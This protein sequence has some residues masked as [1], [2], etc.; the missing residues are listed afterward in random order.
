MSAIEGFRISPQQRRLWSLPDGGGVHARSWCRARLRGRLDLLRLA[1]AVDA[2]VARHEILRTRF[3][4]M[5]GLPCQV[6]LDQRSTSVPLCDLGRLAEPHREAALSE[7]WSIARGSE[8]PP[9]KLEALEMWVVRLGGDESALLVSLPAL[10]ADQ[11]TVENLVAEVASLYV[12]GDACSVDP[13]QVEA[14]P[15]HSEESENEEPLQYADLAEVWNDLLED[16]DEAGASAPWLRGALQRQ[17]LPQTLSGIRPRV[18]VEPLATASLPSAFERRAQ[19]LALPVHVILLTGWQAVIMRLVRDPQA[20]IGVAFDGRTYE[21]M[22]QALGLFARYLPMQVSCASDMTFSQ[23]ARAWLEALSEGETWQ[24]Y[25]DWQQLNGSAVPTLDFGFDARVSKAPFALPGLEVSIEGSNAEIDAIGLRLSCVQHDAGIELALFGDSSSAP[26]AKRMLG[27]LV[28]LLEAAVG[29]PATPIGQLPVLGASDRRELSTLNASAAEFPRHATFSQLFKEQAVASA[30]QPAVVCGVTRWS[31]LELAARSSTLSERLLALGVGPEDVVGILG[32]ASPQTLVA[33]LATLEAGGSFLPLDPALPH[34]RLEMMA[35]D[36]RVGVVIVE[37]HLQHLAPSAVQLVSLDGALS[38]LESASPK[39]GNTPEGRQHAMQ[40]AYQLYTSGS[41]GQPK[42]VTI[43]HHSLLNYLFWIN[44]LLEQA[45]VQILP[46]VTRLS[47]DACLKQLLGPLLEGRPVWL[48]EPGEAADPTRV[49]AGLK[50]R[51]GA[52]LNCV[53][54]YWRAALETLEASDLERPQLGALLLGGEPLDAGLV[55]RTRDVFPELTIWNLYGPTEATSNATACKIVSEPSLG[56]P[57]ANASVHVLD[58][59]LQP[60]PPGYE[61]EICLGGVGVARGYLARPALTAE[62]F[63]P[64]DASSIPGARLY[65]TG[66][67]GCIRLGSVEFLGRLDRQIKVR[68]IRIELGEIE[69]TLRSH[70][71]IADAAVL[72]E[73]GSGERLLA[74]VEAVGGNEIDAP[75][76]DAWAEE[77]LPSYMAL[78]R[79]LV[80]AE[81]PRLPS[82][83]VNLGALAETAADFDSD[84]KQA[85]PSTP[86]ER[87]LAKI[88]SEVLDVEQVGRHDSFFRLGGH[89]LLAV[90]LLSRLRQDLAVELTLRELLD[91]EDLAAMASAIEQA[92]ERDEQ[93]RVPALEPSPHGSEV[94]LSFAQERLWFLA[95]LEPSS[96]AYNI[97]LTL[98]LDGQ[99]DVPALASGLRAIGQRHEVL[100]TS[101]RSDEAGP[102]GVIAERCEKRLHCIDLTGL[103]DEDRPRSEH[104]CLQQEATTAFDLEQAPWRSVLVTLGSDRHLLCLTVHHLMWDGWSTG[105][106]FRELETLYRAA[107]GGRTAGLAKLPLQYADY[108]LWQRRWIQGDVLASLLDYWK[109][110]LAELPTLELPL[111]RPRPPLQT[112]RGS[113]RKLEMAGERIEVLEGVARQHSTTLFVVL[114]AAFNVVLQRITGQSDLVVGTDVANRDQGNTELM[115]GLL[116]N[117]LVLRND[118]STNPTLGEVIERVRKTTL[119]AYGHQ[120]LP[121]NLL[122]DAIQPV[123]DLSRNPL[124]QVV[125]G[126][127]NMARAA[128][129]FDDLTMTPTAFDSG[130]SVIDFSLYL[131]ETSGGMEA[132]VRY[133]TDLF[134]ATTVDRVLAN[135]SSVVTSL[136]GELGR[137]LDAVDVL[138]PSERHQLT[139]EWAGDRSQFDGLFLHQRFERHAIASPNR[140]AITFEGVSWTYGELDRRANQLAQYLKASGVGPEVLVG[141]FFERSRDLVAAVIAVLKAGGAYLPLDPDLPAKRLELIL[142]DARTTLVLTR[143]ALR[144]RLPACEAEIVSLDGVQATLAGMSEES[145]VDLA[146]PDALAYVIYTS[147][148]TGRP[149]G[150]GVTRRNMSRLMTATERWFDFGAEDVWT[151]FHSYAFDFSV[152]EVWGALAHGGRLVIVPWAVSRDTEAF[153]RL[154]AEQGVTVLNQTPSA[155]RQLT[156]TLPSP[157]ALDLRWV[158]FGGEALAPEILEPW[159]LSEQAPA[160]I[161]MY[162]ITETTVHVTFRRIEPSDLERQGTSP[163]GRPIPD[164]ELYL[165]DSRLRNVPLGSRGEVFVAGGG[166]ARGYLDRPSLTA[167]RFVPDPF[168]ARG[169]RLYRTGDLAR[170]RPSGG[171]DF[172][173]RIDHQVQLRGFRIELAEIE[174]VLAS[175]VAVDAVSVVLLEDSSGARIAAYWTGNGGEKVGA[176]VL[177]NHLKGRLPDYMVPSVFVEL[178]EL[179]LTATGKVDRRA[180]PAPGRERPELTEAYEPPA[181]E[182]ESLLQEVWQEALEIDQVGVGDN[183]FGLG[184]DSIRAVRVVASTRARGFE[185]SV[186]DIF[187]NQTIRELAAVIVPAEGPSATPV[188]S[189]PFSLVSPED[190]SQLPAGLEDAYPLTRM[191]RGMLYHME[192]DPTSPAYHNISSFHLRGRFNAE[193][194]RRALGHVMKRHAVLRTSFEMTAFSEPLQLVHEHAEPAFEMEDL[195]DLTEAEQEAVLAGLVDREKAIRFDLRQPPLLRFVVHRLAEDDFWITLAENH[196]ILDGWSLTSILREVFDLHEIFLQGG[197][198]PAE[199]PLTVAFRDYVRLEKEAEASDEQYRFWQQELEGSVLLKLPRRL[200]GTER[201]NVSGPPQ[202]TL[203]V[204]LSPALRAGLAELARA[205]GVP[206][207]SVC[208]AAHVKAMS[209]IGGINDIV[210]GIP[211]Q[212]RPEDVD[213][214]RLRGL[215]INTMPFRA[216]LAAGTWEALVRDVF[217]SE[218]RLMPYRRFPLSALE[219]N[220]HE[221]ALFE[222]L[223]SFVHFHHL[224]AIQRQGQIDFLDD[225]KGWEST[226]FTL[227][228]GFS[229]SPPA[230]EL[231]LRLYYNVRELSARQVATFADCYRQVLNAMVTAPG[232]SH[233]DLDLAELL[234]GEDAEL[235]DRETHIDDM[236]QAFSF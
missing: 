217:E 27:R 69:S 63:V 173:G 228:T 51:P 215:F 121:F 20:A 200:S 174:S 97:P 86:T 13:N 17:G 128:F 161:N 133:N 162:G 135:L 230:F 11:V 196:A 42:G 83:K 34:H 126:F 141:L 12:G 28:A 170:Y 21:G 175:H 74:F 90:R 32:E 137:S 197:V 208:L 190:R 235:L 77:R 145:P 166:L 29:E 153:A 125:F 81:L 123:R 111:D 122:A 109:A 49:L 177:R 50:Q 1:S 213:G 138:R 188:A 159:I 203:P 118:L 43:T 79:L 114:L 87:A 140:Q 18:R 189:G 68:G 206:L 212:G 233:T 168:A 143:E 185:H 234:T 156:R 202:A 129:D 56:Q 25:F 107:S 14:E 116:I 6:V 10:C 157:E 62:R 31:Y 187:Q 183:F 167:E 108:A 54:S 47:F 120:D 95:Q 201:L 151:L 127:Q 102:M 155:F 105:L 184:G 104:A 146:S 186:L 24:D 46:A 71:L 8:K 80:V 147:G 33:L 112:S 89:S 150:V 164:L 70:P 2:V 40:A 178:E 134:D 58:S 152:W 204:E 66:D 144:V 229:L 199:E 154:L 225:F 139:C 57:V 55:E 131:A 115:I 226:D 59:S 179:P 142:S 39:R 207:K 19:Q 7:L 106:F 149:K 205:Q 222:V 72:Q 75:A 219:S 113:L 191:Q 52:G 88:W 100:R 117:Q 158:I 194:F 132:T 223:F 172:L 23:V 4:L 209:L 48:L 30:E 181:D 171:L 93:S 224:E 198:M 192:L 221:Q 96:P 231:R 227:M 180:L 3:E 61:G 9:P 193:A 22:D 99:L 218:R 76:I 165:M 78:S 26:E 220:W 214:E 98:S 103:K 60:Q 35:R 195:V 211:S 85:P 16:E 37:A 73:G 124:F 67:Q 130:T 45:E 44:G 163:I 94:P 65:R 38:E 84:S 236:N 41:S 5:E 210:T 182:L 110:Q 64:D 82:G 36:A 176:S 148:S 216:R 136:D 101:Y 232:A 160:M 53:T 169:G 119:D 15:L 91:A 92:E